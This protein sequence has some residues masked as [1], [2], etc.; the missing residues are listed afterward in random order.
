MTGKLTKPQL[1]ERKNPDLDTLPYPMY[2]TPK[3]DGIRCLSNENGHAVSR[4]LK[5]I[6][7]ECI[8]QCFLDNPYLTGSDGELIVG[9]PTSHSV[10]RDT[11]S[12]VMG[13]KGIPDFKYYIFDIWSSNKKYYEKLEA[14]NAWNPKLPN[15]VHI[16]PSKLVNNKEELL[17]FEKECLELG[18]EGVI[19]RHPEAVYKFGRTTMKECNAFKLKRFT[20]AEAIIVGYVPEYENTNEAEINELGRTKR[21]TMQVGLVPKE[22][23]GSFIVSMPEYGTFNVG[24]GFDHQDRAVFWACRDGLIGATIKFKFFDMGVKDKPRHPIFLGFRDMEID[25]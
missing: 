11:T 3:L 7:N 2:V 6:P 15:W 25:G 20:D 14:L 24:S 23:L 16:V 8:R 4:T 17:S 18:Y 10:M 12:G 22:R 1:L 13:V 19:I 21:S 9:D 5:Q